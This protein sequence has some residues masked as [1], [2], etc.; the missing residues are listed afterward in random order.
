MVLHFSVFIGSDRVA[1]P[2]VLVLQTVRLYNEHTLSHFSF[3]L[4][5]GGSNLHPEV[6]S[7]TICEH[8]T[9]SPAAASL[10]WLV[11]R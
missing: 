2:S 4:D 8:P 9:T 3:E 1:A 5:D 7:V 10:I 6:G 11:E